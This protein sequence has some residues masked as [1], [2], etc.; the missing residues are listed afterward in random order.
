MD[1]SGLPECPLGVD[2]TEKR[3]Q[4]RRLKAEM[5][6]VQLKS[7][8]HLEAASL[9]NSVLSSLGD[10]SLEHRGAAHWM[11][12]ALNAL[13]SGADMIHQHSW[14][15]RMNV[16]GFVAYCSEPTEVRSVRETS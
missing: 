2:L 15:Q 16:L 1:L 10:R 6:S 4:D 3:L 9:S 12:D 14:D 5:P 11:I 8:I 7:G 13:A